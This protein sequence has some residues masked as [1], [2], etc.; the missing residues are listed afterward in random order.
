VIVGGGGGEAG[1]PKNGGCAA[2]EPSSGRRLA[3]S[4]GVLEEM[5]ASGTAVRHRRVVEVTTVQLGRGNTADAASHEVTN[6]SEYDRRL[7]I[8]T[9]IHRGSQEFLEEVPFIRLGDLDPARST[10]EPEKSRA[11]GTSAWLMWDACGIRLGACQW[12]A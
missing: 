5:P 11:F 2:A 6:G 12:P 4:S 10:Q 7:C 8:L 1:A 3:G 9:A